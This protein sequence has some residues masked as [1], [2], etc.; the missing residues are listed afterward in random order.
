MGFKIRSSTR[1][2]YKSY[3]YSNNIFIPRAGNYRDAS[4]PED[5]RIGEESVS[6]FSN[7]A[8][9]IKG[10]PIM[11]YLDSVNRS[12]EWH[13]E[14]GEIWLDEEDSDLGIGIRPVIDLFG[15]YID[16]KAILNKDLN[17][18]ESRKA[19]VFVASLKSEMDGVNLGLGKKGYYDNKLVA[20]KRSDEYSY[21]KELDKPVDVMK[22]I[23]PRFLSS[24]D[25]ELIYKK[26]YSLENK[27][28]G[29]YLS[30]E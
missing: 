26:A 14:V 5:K 19:E 20:L 29:Y 15:K 16:V 25:K 24:L 6:F 4:F 1:G 30:L 2:V 23:R 27:N 17:G 22:D 7:I 12:Y 3:T 28:Y 13:P 8:M 10:E 21:K 9:Q 18:L 11:E